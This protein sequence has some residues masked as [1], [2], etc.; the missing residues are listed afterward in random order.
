MDN[1]QIPPQPNLLLDDLESIRELLDNGTLE[2][3]LLTDSLDQRLP[4]LLSDRLD[5]QQPSA[6]PQPF[7]PAPRSPEP[8]RSALQQ[9]L[10]RDHALTRLD[11]EL[12]AAAQVVLEEVVRDF[13]PQLQAELQRR[14]QERVSQLLPNRR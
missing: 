7:N 10:G 9:S 11:A 2:A 1:P 6:P 8:V 14:L 4:P 13:T 5:Q 12:R 3:P